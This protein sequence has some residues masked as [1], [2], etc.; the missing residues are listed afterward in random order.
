MSTPQSVPELADGE[1]TSVVGNYMGALHGICQSPRPQ[2]WDFCYEHFSDLDRVLSDRQ[3]SCMYLGYYLAS[4]GMLRG[5]TY[6][7]RSTNARHYLKVIDVM[8]DYD[9]ELR[10]V[11]PERFGERDI[12]E[13]LVSAYRDIGNALLPDGGARITLVTKILM[14]IWGVF[15][16]IDTYFLRTFR[17]LEKDAGRRGGFWR[18]SAKTVDFVGDFYDVHKQEIDRLAS[19]YQT[20]DFETGESSGRNLPAAKIIDIY[21]FNAAFNGNSTR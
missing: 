1:I 20:V 3:A 18:F 9:A 21:G 14:G 19:A 5:S 12:Q 8:C 7:F 6:L 15:P 10:G 2:S 17:R 4:W 16:S 13:L 11:T